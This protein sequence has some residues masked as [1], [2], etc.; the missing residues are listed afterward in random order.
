MFGSHFID[1][2]NPDNLLRAV[3]A[4]PDYGVA[5]FALWQADD[6]AKEWPLAHLSVGGILGDC[7]LRFAGVNGYQASL[8]TVFILGDPT[9]RLDP[10]VPA[11]DSTLTTNEWM[12][13]HIARTASTTDGAL[14]HVYRSTNSAIT[15]A[16]DFIRLT[17][18]TNRSD[19]SGRPPRLERAPNGSLHRVGDLSISRLV[20]SE[21][22]PTRRRIRQRR[23]RR[24]P[25]S[26]T[27]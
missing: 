27:A 8:R 20:S 5:S 9:L 15:N 21:Q 12:Q 17:A 24:T 2:N 22:R 16:A 25:R 14:Y 10:V 6:F 26:R 7:Q 4:M 18:T 19:P 11:T 23:S 1:W 13:L 3:L